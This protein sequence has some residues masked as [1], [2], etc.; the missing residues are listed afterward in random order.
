[1]LAGHFGAALGLGGVERRLNLGHLTLAAMFL[2]IL[3]WL[4]VL[5]GV[6]N[7]NVPSNYQSVHYLTF[8][9][10]YSHGLAAVSI[11]TLLAC[12]LTLI[13]TKRGSHR[14]IFAL[15]IA[16]A[17]FSHWLLDFLVHVPEIPLAGEGSEKVGLSLWNHLPIALTLEGALTLVGLVVYLIR[18][19]LSRARGLLIASFTILLVGMTIFGQVLSPPPPSIHQLAAFSLITNLLIVG[20]A[21]WLG[22]RSAEGRFGR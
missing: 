10:P 17:V 11:W 21:Y 16:T 6:E 9:F 20:A 13:L 12:G 2:D 5:I 19:K 8:D 7:V 1:M 14:L 18:R 15:V 4:L 3:L 22:K